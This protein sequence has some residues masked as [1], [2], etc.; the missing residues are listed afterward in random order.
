MIVRHQRESASNRGFRHLAR[1]IQGRGAR[2]RVTWFLAA[3]LPG[4]SGRDDLELACALVDAVQ[5]QN[6]RAAS[7][8]TYHLVIS[9]HRDDRRLDR[10]ELQHV[11]QSLVDAL[12]FSEHQ[13][14]AVR[15]N[16]TDHEHVHVAINKI[17]PE[18]FRI[19]SPAWD[20][21]TLFTG[22]RALER[23]LGLRPLRSRTRDREKIPE[24]AIDCEAHQG[25]NSFARWARENLRPAIRATELRRWDDVHEACSRLGVVIRP[26]GNGLV[27][28]D[29]A[30]GVRV[31]ASFVGRELSKARLCERLRAFEPASERQ[32]EAARQAP[33]RYSPMPARASQSLW[34]EYE[35]TLEEARARRER[36]WARY[37][38]AAA[39][40]RR[41]LKSK[42]RQQRHLLAALPVS[43]RDRKRLF[44]QLELRQTI[45]TRA[46]KQKHATQRWGIQKNPQ[47]GTWN[48]FVATRAAERDARASRLLKSRQ[49]ERDRS[50][51]ER[52]L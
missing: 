27:F 37:R 23:E 31:K 10:R 19:H 21:R 15:H 24:R 1:Y 38:D 12:G 28:E 42:Y 34:K 45:E 26:H 35:Q 6:T 44:Q 5:A 32:L 9:L 49:R 39:L 33:H 13:Y 20:H 48:H 16:D 11:V 17:H 25:I 36:D 41:R 50:S 47:P 7:K 14:I 4:V 51:Q 46:L 52:E 18:T 29:V 2:S 30:R 3:N 8:R 43:G 22:A 40:E